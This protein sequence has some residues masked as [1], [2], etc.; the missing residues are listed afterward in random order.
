MKLFLKLLLCIFVSVVL[1]G[2]GTIYTVSTDSDKLK[3]EACNNDCSIPRVYSGTAFD[4]C[5]ISEEGGSQGEAIL[6]W[7]LLFSIP[8]DTIILPYTFFMQ[9]KEGSIANTEMCL[10]IESPNN[11]SQQDN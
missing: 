1:H 7:D 2:C 3:K 8:A 4:I 10:K 9:I 11:Q 6:F 5:G